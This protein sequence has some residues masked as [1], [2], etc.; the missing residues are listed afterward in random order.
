[1]PSDRPAVVA[2]V[3]AW[4]CVLP[5]ERPFDL[6]ATLLTERDYLVVR[7]TSSDGHQ[8]VAYCLGRG[9]AFAGAVEAVAGELI[10]L[11][12]EAARARQAAR[13][14]ECRLPVEEL[15]TRSLIDICIWDMAGRRLNVPVWELLRPGG[16]PGPLPVLMVEGYA[17]PGEDDN[18]FAARMAARVAG[19]ASALKLR[20]LPDAEA[21]ARRLAATRRAI[22]WDVD[23]VLDAGWGW[24]EADIDVAIEAAR[25]WSPYRLA[26]LEDPFPAG[27]AA[28]T[29][30][31]RAASPIA[32]GAGD[33]FDP[34]ALG[35]LLAHDA[36]EILRVDA[37][38]VGGVTGF[39]AMREAA[40]HGIQI[41]PH[42]SAEVHQHCAF[43]CDAVAPVEL[44]ASDR[45]FDAA[46]AF[47]SDS[48]LAWSGGGE[49]SPPTGPGLGLHVDR[50]SV[51][52]TAQ[53]SARFPR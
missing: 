18:A 13:I 26:W 34:V 48:S 15:R 28:V 47:V 43:A 6:G 30:E 24:G 20:N 21:T 22:G 33:E 37:T 44:F 41:S 9:G 51:I 16:A 14:R 29:A 1:V 46:C 17:V 23:L 31:L 32:I 42:V 8:G 45:Q 40:G 11:D 36:V 49:I 35:E 19:G 25:T 50:T 3:E 38:T 52:G 7:L 27:H 5:I 12:E 53:W 2:S 10:G 4:L 39:M